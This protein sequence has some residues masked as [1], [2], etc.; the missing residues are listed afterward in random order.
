[1]HNP[2]PVMVLGS[3]DLCQDKDVAGHFGVYTK[4]NFLRLRQVELCIAGVM[5]VR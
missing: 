1:M 4:E 2:S 3:V 5:A